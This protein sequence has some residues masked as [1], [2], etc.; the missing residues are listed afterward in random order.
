[1][2]AIASP[3][4]RT[5]VERFK[6]RFQGVDSTFVCIITLSA[7]LHVSTILHA[8]SLPEPPHPMVDEV[9][10]R[11]PKVYVV[12][13]PKV[14]SIPTPAVVPEKAEEPVE[15][16][17][18]PKSVK[19]RT[20]PPPAQVASVQPY[21]PP[22]L[23]PGAIALIE[24]LKNRGGAK[25]AF[26][27]LTNPNDPLP[28]LATMIG[29]GRPL[30]VGPSA[31]TGTLKSSGGSETLVGS[32]AP[33]GNTGATAGVDVASI[34]HK[35]PSA[36]PV[37]VPEAEQVDG[38]DASNLNAVFKRN[39]GGIVGCYENALKLN[40]AMAGKFA[41]NLVITPQGGVES[42]SLR[43]V[44]GHSD[45]AFSD[46]VATRVKHWRFAKMDD[47]ADVTFNLFLT[48]QSH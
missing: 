45:E 33:V 13:V 48:P 1:M 47:S 21:H 19:P 40:P 8:M 4:R 41:L 15:K 37:V 23:P 34:P 20:E 22:A 2:T 36:R 42:S 29:Q 25:G 43:A 9:L 10:D 16:P 14:E 39:L 38:A 7:M 3:F 6:D 46:C 28:D 26:A 12:V 32:F 44:S 24:A 35:R 30:Q 31:S 18:P 5:L 11:F 17:R 27:Q